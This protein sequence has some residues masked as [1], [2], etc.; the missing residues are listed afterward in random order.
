MTYRTGFIRGNQLK[1]FLKA[2]SLLVWMGV[3]LMAAP[4]MGQ[5]PVSEILI[6]GHRCTVVSPADLPSNAPLVL[7]LHGLGANRE[8]LFALCEDLHLPPCLFV[9]PDA[10]ISLSGSSEAFAWYDQSTQSRPD[11]EKSRDYLFEIMD[12]FSLEDSS[13]S[14]SGKLPEPRPILIMG[15]SQGG[16]MSLEAGLNY[17]GKIKAIVSM[18]GYMAD[19]GKTLAHASAPFKTPILLVH[20]TEDHIVSE[21][22]THTTLEALIKAGYHPVLKEFPMRHQITSDSLGEVSKFLRGVLADR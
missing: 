2:K 8:D 3:L 21:E 12:R 22:W 15:F 9:L 16:V 17:K 4:L 18:S 6:Q 7:I 5:T 20:G 11:V 14:A 10:P 1:Y 19:P 13:P